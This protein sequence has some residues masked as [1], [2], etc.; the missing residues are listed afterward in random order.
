MTKRFAFYIMVSGIKN[1]SFGKRKENFMKNKKAK[2]MTI[3][4]IALAILSAVLFSLLIS[5]TAKR[6]EAET[7]LKNHYS[8]L[9]ESAKDNFERYLETGE[10][11]LYD[12]GTSDIGAIAGIYW[13][14]DEPKDSTHSLLLIAQGRLIDSGA[15]KCREALPYLIEALDRALEGNEASF[16]LHLQ[17]FRNH[18]HND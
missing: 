17:Y 7:D 18:T 16:D 2:P 12:Y 5:E 3:V 6:R 9:I 11:R 15:E 10:E 1:L 14:M 13:L 4:C 8:S